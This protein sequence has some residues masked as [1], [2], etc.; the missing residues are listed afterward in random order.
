MEESKPEKKKLWT[1]YLTTYIW[2]ASVLATLIHVTFTN[3]PGVV[4]DA[5][6]ALSFGVLVTG[7]MISSNWGD[8]GQ[9]SV[10]FHNL[11][12]HVLPFIVVTTALISNPKPA[13]SL[14]KTLVLAYMLP[15]IYDLTARDPE[16]WYRRFSPNTRIHMCRIMLTVTITC[17]AVIRHS[18]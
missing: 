16:A 7:T 3:A 10:G 17:G 14:W 18:F 5:A 2:W 6:F 8:K 4:T 13:A 12:L 11:L 9:N 1:H 15:L